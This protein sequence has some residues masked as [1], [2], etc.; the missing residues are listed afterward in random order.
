MDHGRPFLGQRCRYVVPAG[1]ADSIGN[2]PQRPDGLVTRPRPLVPRERPGRQRAGGRRVR[3]HRPRRGPGRHGAR[4]RGRARGRRRRAPRARR[5]GGRDHRRPRRGPALPPRLVVGEDIGHKAAAANLADVAAM[6]ATTTALLVGAGLP[7]ATPRPRG[8]RASRRGSPRSAPP[9][10][11]AVVGGDTVDAAADSAAVVLSVTALGDLGGRSP[12]LRSGA[13]AGDVVALAGRLGWSAAGLAVLR[14]GVPAAGRRG[15]RRTG[16]PPRR[17]PPA[18][19]P[20]SAGATAMCDVS[21]GL[22]ADLGHIAAAS[23]GRPRPGP[24][25][26]VRACL[27][28]VGPAAAGRCGAGRR[29][30]G[31]GAHR[32]RGPRAGGDLPVVGRAARGLGRDRRRAQGRA[33]IPA[34]W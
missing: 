8:W 25:G 10:G 31:L 7:A 33:R 16:G 1:V 12:V 20:P 5:P 24:R 21:D 32:G 17:T 22:L 29:S 19:P 11:A 27:E 4:R 9:L 13:R 15:R 34:C 2:L 3:G 23:R 6:G 18:R 14:R 26:V 28:P 30:A